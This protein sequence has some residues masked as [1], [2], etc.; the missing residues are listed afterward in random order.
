MAE[1]VFV[2]EIER[3]GEGVMMSLFDR[4][5]K[6]DIKSLITSDFY[7]TISDALFDVDKL[8]ATHDG[9]EHL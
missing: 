8:I 2:V 6:S 1:V 5:V 3:S 7:Y 9:W 4:G